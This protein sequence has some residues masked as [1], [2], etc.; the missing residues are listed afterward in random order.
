MIEDKAQ[1]LGR[2]IGQSEEYKAVMRASEALN[3]DQEAIGLRDAVDNLRKEA[4][5]MLARG[6]EPTQ[7][8]EEQLNGLLARIQANPTYQHLMV[9]EENLD[10]VM[11]RVNEWISDG[12]S[13]GA[14]SPI[15]TLG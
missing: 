12:I 13:K 14:K 15:I 1:E 10:K 8:M 11:R 2:L 7:A 4:Q 3:G 6:E 9:A 5:D